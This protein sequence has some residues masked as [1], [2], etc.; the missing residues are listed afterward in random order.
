MRRTAAVVLGVLALAGCTA[1]EDLTASAYTA[2]QQNIDAQYDAVTWPSSADVTVDGDVYTVV[3]TVEADGQQSEATC[4]LTRE[5]D[6]W[7]L[8]SYNVVAE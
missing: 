1:T 5:D 7:L 6:S 3:A 2:C 8:S 4:E